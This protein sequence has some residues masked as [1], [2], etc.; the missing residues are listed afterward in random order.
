MDVKKIQVQ[1]SFPEKAADLGGSCLPFQKPSV[2]S[3]GPAVQPEDGLRASNRLPR[4]L[5][6]GIRLQ[7]QTVRFTVVL[8]YAEFQPRLCA[9]P[10]ATRFFFNKHP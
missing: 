7:L 8:S 10:I 9:N 6:S 4:N 5:E 3:A 1:I 2:A